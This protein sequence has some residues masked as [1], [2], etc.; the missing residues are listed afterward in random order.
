MGV[1]NETC[2]ALDSDHVHMTK[3]DDPTNEVYQ[4]IVR[5][6]RELSERQTEGFAEAAKAG[7]FQRNDDLILRSS[8]LIKYDEQLTFKSEGIH[9]CWLSW[10]EW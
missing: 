10:I 9:R 1:P 6:I 5:R 3:F 7:T 8:K 4:L 2:V